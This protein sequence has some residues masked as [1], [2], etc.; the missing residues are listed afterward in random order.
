MA[1]RS[2]GSIAHPSSRP[3]TALP[4]SC[5]PPRRAA[6][7]LARNSVPELRATGATGRSERGRTHSSGGRPLSG[8]DSRLPSTNLVVSDAPA[9]GRSTRPRVPQAAAG[10]ESRGRRA[11]NGQITCVNGGSPRRAIAKR[12][13]LVGRSAAVL[14]DEEWHRATARL[15]AGD[16]G[17]H[18]PDHP[19]D[20]VFRRPSGTYVALRG[21]RRRTNAGPP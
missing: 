1:A 8:R 12:P 9:D 15:V 6:P 10:S 16:L 17:G 7:R 20:S 14:R 18:L 4:P 2:G 19:R 11:A 5:S 21:R 13:S 3:K